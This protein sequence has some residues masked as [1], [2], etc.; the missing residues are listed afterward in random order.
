M[1]PTETIAQGPRRNQ[2]AHA[3]SESAT[4]SGPGPLELW[5]GLE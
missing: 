1:S 3:T 4:G 5:D 2:H